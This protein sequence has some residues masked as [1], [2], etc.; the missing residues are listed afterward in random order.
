M[1]ADPNTRRRRVITAVETD[2]STGTFKE[3]FNNKTTTKGK[4]Y[5]QN[6]TVE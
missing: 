1:D 6:R 5:N 2:P 4:T 3:P